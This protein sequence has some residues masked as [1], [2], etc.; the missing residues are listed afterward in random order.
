MLKHSDFVVLHAAAEAESKAPQIIRYGV[1]DSPFGAFLLAATAKGF[2]R[3]SFIFDNDIQPELAYLTKHWPKAEFEQDNAWAAKHIHDWFKLVEVPLKPVV[4]H[5]VGTEFQLQ[6]WQAL[7]DIP[8][9]YTSTYSHIA[10][11]VQRP[12]AFRAVGTAVGQNP[13][14]FLVPCHRVLQ[15]SGALGGYFWG[16]PL[17][18]EL[19]AWESINKFVSD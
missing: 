12:K 14:T 13:I 19:L 6:V 7:L 18:Q 15:T 5:L 2:C 9:G 4:L 16:L 1:G 17:K 10:Q 8:L 11:L 3:A